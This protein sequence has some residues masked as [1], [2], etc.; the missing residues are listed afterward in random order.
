VL[1][2]SDFSVYSDEEDFSD[3]VPVPDATGEYEDINNRNRNQ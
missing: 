1:V 2:E 3:P